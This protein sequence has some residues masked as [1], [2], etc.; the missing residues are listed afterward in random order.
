MRLFGIVWSATLLGLAACG[1]TG[2]YTERDYEAEAVVL[3]TSTP[4]IAPQ[5]EAIPKTGGQ[6]SRHILNAIRRDP[7]VNAAMQA[8]N[9]ASAGTASA[10]SVLRPQVS[11]SLLAG[12]YQDDLANGS[13]KSAAAIDA[14][15]TQLLYDGGGALSAVSASKLELELAEVAALLAANDVASKAASVWLETWSA[16]SDLV[17]LQV[18]EDELLPHAKQVQRMANSGLIDRSVSDMIEG[19][20]IEFEMSKQEAQYRLNAAS[21]VFRDY[22]GMSPW[23]LS[24]PDLAFKSSEIVSDSSENAAPIVRQAA[25]RV[26]LAREQKAI[27]MAKFSPLVAVEAGANSPMDR[28]DDPS[29]RVGINVSFQ[30]SDGGKRKADLLRAKKSVESAEFSLASVRQVSGQTINDLVER[31]LN[32][33]QAA[34]LTSE[35]VSVLGRRLKDA[36]TQIQTGQADVAKVFEMKVQRHQLE[37]ALRM[38]R[39]DLRRVEYQIAAALGLFALPM[40]VADQ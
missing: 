2:D 9:A 4:V 38:A 31:R 23:A 20:T 15:V 3:A 19:R 34:Q 21:Y 22:F 18:L 33:L 28:S 1:G 35:K 26:L 39:A 32:V 30:F 17:A 12:G 8:M 11:G 25:L 36:Q 6:L 5:S 13:A 27:A 24:Y 37:S 7:E 29:G 16:Q 10:K 14:K 40:S